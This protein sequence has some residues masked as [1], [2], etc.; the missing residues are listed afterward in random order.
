MTAII[1]TFFSIPHRCP[2]FYGSEGRG[3]KRGGAQLITFINKYN[4]IPQYNIPLEQK[5]NSEKF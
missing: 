2:A 3:K 4:N 1:L 5:L